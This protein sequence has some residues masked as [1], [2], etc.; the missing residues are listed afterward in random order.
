MDE[1][2]R[3]RFL[4]AAAGAGVA[5]AGGILA[6]RD[7]RDD[8]APAQ[9]SERSRGATSR[10]T[11]RFGLGDAGIANFLLTLQ[12]IERDLYASALASGALAARTRGLFA[13]FLRQERAHA[14]EL[15]AAVADLGTRTV[16]A[17]RVDL[18]LTSET[19]F[20]QFAATVEGLAASA[21]L[22]QLRAIDTR[23]LLERVVAIHS[24]DGRHAAAVSE[25]AGLD[26][27]PDGALAE[28]ADAATVLA[29][30]R[31]ILRS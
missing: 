14:A 5:A 29:K 18:P 2:S 23:P 19:G 22:G 15:E 24:V 10:T 8:G 20:V 27:A 31:P 30:L 12:R 28:P 17:P 3:R 25:L 9:A 26:P 4:A 1:R 13:D 11:D 21:C 7:S 16:R 6:T